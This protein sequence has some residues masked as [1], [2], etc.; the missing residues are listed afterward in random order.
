MATPTTRQGACVKILIADDHDLVREAIGRML[1]DLFEACTVVEAGDL[2]AAVACFESD[3]EGFDLVLLDLRMP[4]MNGLD[5]LRRMVQLAGDVPVALLSGAYQ[6]EDVR[7]AI[8]VGAAGFFPKTLRGEAL[9]NALRLVLSGEKYLPAAI[10]SGMGE[11][12]QGDGYRGSA[13]R[14]DRLGGHPEFARLTPREREVLALL[15]EGR[16]NKDIARQLDLREI[17]VKYHLK[18]I[19][20]KLSVTNRAQAVKMAL[21]GMAR[22]GTL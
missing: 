12:S 18:N 10:L 13:V 1:V 16:P 22:T 2:D 4:G 5:G 19:Y 14:P 11:S 6:G 7:E 15:A 9:M 21:E 3:S 20:R 8:E 17:T